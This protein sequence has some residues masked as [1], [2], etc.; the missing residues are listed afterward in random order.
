MITSVVAWNES[1]YWVAV[2]MFIAV[3]DGTVVILECDL[4]DDMPNFG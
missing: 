4:P 1:L 3:V 2:G